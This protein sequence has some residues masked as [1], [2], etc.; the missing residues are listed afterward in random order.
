MSLVFIF[1]FNDTV[2]PINELGLSIQDTKHEGDEVFGVLFND[3]YKGFFNL[4]NWN[5]FLL[6]LLFD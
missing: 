6:N 2:S 3:N 4:V 5:K 1:N